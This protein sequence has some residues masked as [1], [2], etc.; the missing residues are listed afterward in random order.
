MIVRVTFAERNEYFT[1]SILDVDFP[2]ILH[3]KF[4]E[5]SVSLF[6]QNISLVQDYRSIVNEYVDILTSHLYKE[7]LV[8]GLLIDNSRFRAQVVGHT[9]LVDIGNYPVYI[10]NMITVHGSFNKKN[11][12]VVA[13]SVVSLES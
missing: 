12:G 3:S 6:S 7:E 8:G 1:G 13:W 11:V 9:E 2:S 4:M 5:C 10:G